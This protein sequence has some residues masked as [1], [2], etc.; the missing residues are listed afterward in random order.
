MQARLESDD[1]TFRSHW[2]DLADY[3]FPRER[4]ITVF[5]SPGAP[6]FDRL[7]DITAVRS[8]ERMADGLLSYMVPAGQK[9]FMLATS[10]PRLQEIDAVKSYLAESTRLLH[11][12][13]FDSNFQSQLKET[14]RSLIVFGTGC[15]FSEW[16]FGLNFRDWDIARYQIDEEGYRGVVDVIY[17]R[18]PMTA[19]Q[20]ANKW[21]NN[22]GRSIADA[23][24]EEKTRYKKFDF[25]TVVRPRDKFN[26]RFKNVLNMP[27]EEKHVSV[28]DKIIVAEGGYPQFPYHVS[29]WAQSSGEVHGRGIGGMILPQVKTLNAIKRDFNEMVNKL[30]NPP[31]EVLESFEG[32]YDTTPGA[33]NNVMEL[34]SSRVDERN[35][36]NFPA[37]K[38][39]LE[40]ERQ[41]V[42]DAFYD[43]AFAPLTALTGD[44]R[45]ELEI[46]Q[47]IQEA[48]RTIGQTRRLE[49]ELFTP[50]I[51]RCY[52]LL[53][54]NQVVPPPPSELVG[55]KMKIMYRGPLSLAQQDSEAAA[56]DIWV[57]K[58]MAVANVDPSVLD[59]I[60]LDS[61]MRRWGRVGGVNE[62]DIATEEDVDDR[63]EARARELQRQQALEMAQVA[64][65]AYA[66]TVKAPEEGSGAEQMG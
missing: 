7:Y 28:K 41:L 66:Q 21:G 55:Q 50:L 8:S 39:E 23:M 33:R 58:G 32:E 60:N 25:I 37:G 36:G 61:V 26:P 52:Y 9:F 24:K 10:D 30:V 6:Q 48:L 43:H 20:A 65:G 4:E 53:L 56:A 49:G 22:A 19:I 46:R 16:N 38:D 35:F 11:E 44:R 3:I 27:W 54:A 2:Q 29:R 42:K 12:E 63:R 45:N 64:A 62:D 47:R 51:E 1:A 17:I 5:R 40:A 13:L 31:R 18:Y 15:L 59:H 34:P 14:F 57:E